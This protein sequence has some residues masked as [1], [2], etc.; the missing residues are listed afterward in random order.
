LTVAVPWVRA[1]ASIVNCVIWPTFLLERHQPKDRVD[2]GVH[3]WID[4][5]LAGRAAS[6]RQRGH[7]P[8]ATAY[9]PDSASAWG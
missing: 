9:H 5:A 3:P 6:N 4:C 2:L 8:S 7:Q 1:T